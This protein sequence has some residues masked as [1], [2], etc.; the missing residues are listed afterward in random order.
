MLKFATDPPPRQAGLGGST[1]LTSH[2]CCL[3]GF[4]VAGDAH[5]VPC[6]L[7]SKDDLFLAPNGM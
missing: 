2:K 6:T 7:F 1:N 4:H 3:P 5:Q